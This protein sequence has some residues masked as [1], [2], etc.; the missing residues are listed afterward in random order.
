MVQELD[1]LHLAQLILIT[2]AHG[3]GLLQQVLAVAGKHA[4][5]VSLI[6]VKIAI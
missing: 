1:V 2:N 5:M 6:A 3:L 4:E